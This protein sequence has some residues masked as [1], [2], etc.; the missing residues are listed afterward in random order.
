[1][2]NHISNFLTFFNLF[3]TFGLD[4]DSEIM[5]LECRLHL[6]FFGMYSCTEC[7][8]SDS[9]YFFENDLKKELGVMG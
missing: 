4:F 1:M 8:F 9:S 2:I 3:L 6:F 7:L 5:F